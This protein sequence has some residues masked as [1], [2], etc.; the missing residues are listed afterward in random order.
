MRWTLT[1][2]CLVAGVFALLAGCHLGDSRA[3]ESEA[4]PAGEDTE[5]PGGQLPVSYRLRPATPVEEAPGDP[6]PAVRPV[7]HEADPGRVGRRRG[8]EHT[9]PPAWPAQAEPL[10]SPPSC[11][12][13]VDYRW[14]VGTLEQ[15]ARRRLWQVRYAAEG[16]EPYGGV[17]ELVGPG[18]MGGF[19]AGQWV[20]VEGEL[21]D[22]AP[23]QTRPA[24]RV[25][26]LQA[27]L[28]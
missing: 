22:P 14:L 18:P 19:R 15:D 12:R 26:A 1:R 11:G 2:P 25:R 28:R 17:L 23:H 10:G 21:I 13:A 3:P 5:L 27:L 7:R 8:R 6:P 20:R 9:P 16:E 4:V 24:Y